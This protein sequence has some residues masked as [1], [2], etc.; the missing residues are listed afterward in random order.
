MLRGQSYTGKG[1]GR[2][3]DGRKIKPGRNLDPDK[4][5]EGELAANETAD[6]SR[7]VEKMHTEKPEHSVRS[8]SRHTAN[9][10]QGHGRRNPP[11]AAPPAGL[12]N[13]HV[14]N[15]YYKKIS[16]LTKYILSVG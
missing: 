3:V 8:R 11:E 13:S 12:G 1:K 16:K 2:E 5:T 7:S 15:C 10:H 14:G 9:V 4:G 6:Y